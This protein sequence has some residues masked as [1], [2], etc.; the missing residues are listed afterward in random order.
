[1]WSR[2]CFVISLIP[3]VFLYFPYNP[4]PVP[5]LP[6]RYRPPGYSYIHTAETLTGSIGAEKLNFGKWYFV[7]H[8]VPSLSNMAATAVRTSQNV[9]LLMSSNNGSTPALY[10]FGSFLWRVLPKQQHEMTRICEA[11]DRVIQT[12][13]SVLKQ[14]FGCLL[15][16]CHDDTNTQLWSSS[17]RTVNTWKTHRFFFLKCE[18]QS[19][20]ESELWVWSKMQIKRKVK[21][22]LKRNVIAQ[23]I[24]FRIKL[25][26][27][28]NKI[29]VW[30]PRT[31]NKKFTYFCWQFSAIIPTLQ[32][33]QFYVMYTTV[34]TNQQLVKIPTQ[35]RFVR[36]ETWDIA[37]VIQNSQWPIRNRVAKAEPI[38]SLPAL[39]KPWPLI[40]CSFQWKFLKLH[41][42]ENSLKRTL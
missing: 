30:W 28:A 38:R 6:L 3:N 23:Q 32:R 13:I 22:N 29:E 41:S 31:A 42:I 35:G 40:C 33:C 25:K 21:A 10:F 9:G 14:T 4:S 1:M 18:I 7:K 11:K 2:A 39:Y 27:N 5:Y 37:P 36:R 24:R 19:A 15:S 34:L 8:Y 16:P 26:H 12:N 20:S 17:I